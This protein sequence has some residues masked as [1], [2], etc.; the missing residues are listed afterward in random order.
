MATTNFTTELA[1]LQSKNDFQTFVDN[2]I[3]YQASQ[4]HLDY[5]SDQEVAR[6]NANIC[7]IA[8]VIKSRFNNADQTSFNPENTSQSVYIGSLTS[9]QKNELVACV[10]GLGYTCSESGNRMTINGST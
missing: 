2:A 4:P 8:K 6:Q 5:L 10:E 7:H 3:T 1:A 9:S